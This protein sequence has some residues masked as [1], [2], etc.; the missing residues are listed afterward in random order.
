ML[1]LLHPQ[2]VFVNP[3]QKTQESINAHM[4][5]Y[6]KRICVPRISW[7]SLELRDSLLENVDLEHVIWLEMLPHLVLEAVLVKDML[8]GVKVKLPDQHRLTTKVAQLI[9]CNET[10]AVSQLSNVVLD[11]LGR[12][13][14]LYR[15]DG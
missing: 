12:T 8:A 13:S 6:H 4:C 7:L 10:E 1:A 9:R 3:V 5:Y 14:R 11:V 2:Y 15:G